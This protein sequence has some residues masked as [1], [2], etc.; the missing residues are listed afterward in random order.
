MFRYSFKL[1]TR[2]ATRRISHLSSLPW[3]RLAVVIM[4]TSLSFSIPKAQALANFIN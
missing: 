4:L 1:T 2:H 3:Y